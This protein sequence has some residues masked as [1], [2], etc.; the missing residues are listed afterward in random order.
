M[1]ALL[2]DSGNTRI[3]VAIAV[4]GNLEEVRTFERDDIV[5][6]LSFADLHRVSFCSV[7]DV[8]GRI[9]KLIV[10]LRKRYGGGFLLVSSQSRVPFHT[11]T[12]FY[13]TMGAD[14]IAGLVGAY[15]YLSTKGVL[16]ID[17]GTAI[18]Y[19]YLDAR[20]RYCGGL[21]SM[22]IDMRRRALH[23]FTGCLPLVDIPTGCSYPFTMQDTVS[24]LQSGIVSGLVGEFE[25][26]VS[27][28]RGRGA[29]FDVLLTGGDAQCLSNFYFC[30][31]FVV[32]NLV[33]EGLYELLECNI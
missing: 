27:Q 15:K 13:N 7:C 33:L 23:T 8:S 2:V 21:I 18:T 4:D 16:V 24:S 3:K 19:D 26:L 12:L 9:E 29:D 11:P 25:Y 14:R 5:P 10:E 6:L 28:L 32:Q 30:K 31:S 1:R 17:A 20:G 22:G